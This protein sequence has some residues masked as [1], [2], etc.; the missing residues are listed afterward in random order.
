MPTSSKTRKHFL[1]S[2][3]K[4]TA[5]KTMTASI[6]HVNTV[7]RPGTYV[8]FEHPLRVSS[9]AR[10]ASA[11]SISSAAA[12][13]KSAERK[14]PLTCSLHDKDAGPFVFVPC[15]CDVQSGV[16]VCVCVCVCGRR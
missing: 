11:L 9:Q 6:L 13:R 2:W 3:Q 1:E 5:I 7:P 12:T 14:E 15:M 10:S 8:L 4:Y 16:C